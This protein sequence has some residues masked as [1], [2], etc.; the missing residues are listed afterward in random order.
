MSRKKDKPKKISAKKE[1]YSKF[2]KEKPS[3]MTFAMPDLSEEQVQQRRFDQERVDDF[4]RHYRR[5]PQRFVSERKA[6]S[7]R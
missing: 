5:P 7:K 4:W 2:R 6:K 1:R 3:S